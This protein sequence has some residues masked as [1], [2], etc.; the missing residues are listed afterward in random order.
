MVRSCGSTQVDV[1]SRVTLAV[2][3]I[4]LLIDIET[5]GCVEPQRALG[6]PPCEQLGGGPVAVLAVRAGPGEDQ[7]NHVVGAHGLVG[8][9]RRRGDDVVGRGGDQARVA[10]DG[11]IETEASEGGGG[12]HGA[13]GV[14]CS[15]MARL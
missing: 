4:G 9:A 11:G 1:S 8:R 2:E 12:Y 6:P 10:D 3:G 5:W 7:P 13:A 14:R 15:V